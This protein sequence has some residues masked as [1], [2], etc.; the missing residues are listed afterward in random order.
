MLLTLGVEIA[1][2]L[3][4]AHAAGIVHRDIKPANIF[5]TP[6]GHV[7]ILDFG[8]AKMGGRSAH[9]TGSAEMTFTATERGMVLG[10]A[11]YMSPEQSLGDLV[12]HRADIWALVWCDEMATG[13]SAAAVRLRIEKW[14]ELR[15]SRRPRDR[16]RPVT[17]THPTF[18]PTQLEKRLSVPM[19][20]TVT[21]AE[22]PNSVRRR[23]ILRVRQL[24]WR[25]RSQDTY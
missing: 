3:D 19:T 14:P 8:L 16:P 4:A 22:S 12:D 2:A 7:K 24:R 18:A 21:A 9:D 6:R 20:A 11:A 25:S 23:L 1:D 17:S 10:T 5:I 15:M 13:T